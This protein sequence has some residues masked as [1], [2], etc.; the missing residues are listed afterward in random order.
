MPNSDRSTFSLQQDSILGT[1]YNAIVKNNLIVDKKDKKL[2][3]IA[4]KGNSE[5]ELFRNFLLKFLQ[6]KYP[7]FM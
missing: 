6:K 3:I 2:I 1:F 5:N 7:I 4:V